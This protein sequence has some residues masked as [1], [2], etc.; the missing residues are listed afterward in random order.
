MYLNYRCK[1]F[2]FLVS[3]HSTISLVLNIFKRGYEN[4]FLPLKHLISIYRAIVYVAVNQTN[5]VPSFLAAF[6]KFVKKPFESDYPAPDSP[7]SNHIYGFATEISKK[8]FSGG[9]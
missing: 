5:A 1:I 8:H 6:T 4:F 3:H 9:A 2:L 7:V